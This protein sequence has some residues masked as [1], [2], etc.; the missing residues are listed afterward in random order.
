MS[1]RTRKILIYLTLPAAIIWGVFNLPGNKDQSSVAP[2]QQQL[3]P[4]VV[5]AEKVIPLSPISAHLIN[6]EE[7]SAQKW[8]ADPFR[9]HKPK[10]SRIASSTPNRNWVLQGIVYKTEQPM[11]F[12]NSR[13]VK[14]GDKIDDATVVA[15]NKKTVT[16]EYNGRRIDLSVNKG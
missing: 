13:S 11:A 12:I 9:T 8:G 15:I 10:N 4:Q 16:L 3:Q 6:I 1:D 14:V 5:A 2:A 7:K